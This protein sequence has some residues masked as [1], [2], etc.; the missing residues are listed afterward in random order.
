MG[1]EN[2]RPLGS[3]ENSEGLEFHGK[4]VLSPREGELNHEAWSQSKMLG[5]LV[6]QGHVTESQ[7]SK[8]QAGAVE[9]PAYQVRSH[10]PETRGVGSAHRPFEVEPDVASCSLRLLFFSIAILFC[11]FLGFI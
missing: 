1:P 10:R 3:V 2:G 11:S 4:F 7:G 6:P 8:K 9:V 5:D